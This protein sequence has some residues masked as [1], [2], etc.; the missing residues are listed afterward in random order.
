LQK[1]EGSAAY[2]SKLDLERICTTLPCRGCFTGTALVNAKAI[3][4]DPTEI[5]VNLSWKLP[6]SFGVAIIEG[7]PR[8]IQ[9]S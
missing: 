5:R 9:S 8:R 1:K 4:A 3:G 6:K 2:G 7:M